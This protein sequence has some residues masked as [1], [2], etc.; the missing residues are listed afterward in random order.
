[1]E[2]FGK[3]PLAISADQLGAVGDE[4]L[5]RL[6]SYWLSK[7]GDRVVTRRADIDPVEMVWILPYVWLFDYEAVSH[8]FRCRL[9]GEA[10]LATYAVNI[11]GK[12]L[13]EI[14]PM[15]VWPDIE[16]L[17]TA[18]V[19]GP[20]IGYISG[21]AYQRTPHRAIYAERIVLPLSTDD[22]ET[23]HMVLGATLWRVLP[24]EQYH[25]ATD[26]ILLP[27]SASQP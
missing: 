5:R 10:I 21:H 9:A 18:V 17:Y 3:P 2:L 12:Y 13:D 19:L 15:E 24:R 22:G 14:R 25:A 6:V 8:R 4:R 20:A 27:L 26:R 23:V 7:R 1:M 16:A 11:V